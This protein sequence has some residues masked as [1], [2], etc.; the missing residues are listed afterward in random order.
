MDPHWESD[1]EALLA[2]LDNPPPRGSEADLC[3]DTLAERVQRYWSDAPQPPS[4]AV[5]ERLDDLT[6]RLADFEKRRAE[7]HPEWEA[8]DHH[9]PG[10]DTLIA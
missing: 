3:I 9:R 4:N 10:R 1:L 8:A 7:A 5:S 6:R 2:L